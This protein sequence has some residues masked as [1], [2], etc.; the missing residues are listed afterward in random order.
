MIKLSVLIMRLIHQ[1]NSLLMKKKKLET[2]HH[3]TCLIYSQVFCLRSVF[4]YPKSSGREAALFITHLVGCEAGSEEFLVNGSKTRL[5]CLSL[6]P[7]VVVCAQTVCCGFGLLYETYSISFNRHYHCICLWGC[8]VVALYI[9]VSLK[10]QA[11]FILRV[12]VERLSQCFS[13]SWLETV[14]SVDHTQPP[15]HQRSSMDSELKPTLSFCLLS[16]APFNLC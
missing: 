2:H 6:R 3:L 13:S 7:G 11:E 16:P 9:H 15:L 10:V 1:R 4:Q 14:P 8:G 5:Q 12:F